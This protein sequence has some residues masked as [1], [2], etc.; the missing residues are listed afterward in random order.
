MREDRQDVDFQTEHRCHPV[1]ASSVIRRVAPARRRRCRSGAPSSWMTVLRTSRRMASRPPGPT[2]STIGS[3]EQGDPVGRG[4]VIA[5]GPVEPV[6]ALVQAEQIFV[7]VVAQAR[8]PPALGSLL[9]QNGHVVE[10]IL[11]ISRQ[12][13]QRLGDQRLERAQRRAR[14]DVAAS[15]LV[16]RQPVGARRSPPG[17]EH[18]NDH[19]DHDHQADEHVDPLQLGHR[20]GL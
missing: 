10:A 20:P 18:R 17:H 11:N 7:R 4:Q 1:D 2:S 5:A 19:A 9:D 16:A 14:R 13:V 3:P 8:Q 15:P 6:D 12:V